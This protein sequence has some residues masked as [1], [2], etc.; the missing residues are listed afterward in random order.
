MGRPRQQQLGCQRRLCRCCRRCR[1]MMRLHR[2]LSCDVESR[3]GSALGTRTTGASS[4]CRLDR[5]G[6][7]PPL[8][9][10]APQPT[11]E[12]NIILSAMKE[13]TGTK[14]NCETE[15]VAAPREREDLIFHQTVERSKLGERHR[16]RWSKEK[17]QRR[18]HAPPA[19][20]C[21][22]PRPLRRSLRRRRPVWLTPRRCGDWLGRCAKAFRRQMRRA[23]FRAR[24][25]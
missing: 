2:M 19:A 8:P 4:C 20:C 21:P 16:F 22:H 17:V 24:R 25:Y 23:C 6:S 1:I 10:W 3:R 14:P 18:L 15:A 12:C 5:V 7:P 9:P 11:P 13:K